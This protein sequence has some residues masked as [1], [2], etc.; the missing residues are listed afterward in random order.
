MIRLLLI[1]CFLLGQLL[2]FSRDYDAE[3]LSQKTNITV[4]NGKLIKTEY[5]EIKINNRAGDQYTKVTIPYSKLGKITK[6]HAYI[7]NS[8]GKVIRHI[9]K[10]EITDRSSISDF[11]FYEDDYVKEFTLKHNTYP[12]TI[13]FSY[14]THQDEFLY[15]DSWTPVI[16]NE[17][18]THEATLNL[19]IQK[20]YPVSFSEQLIDSTVI[21]TS[22]S[23][24]KYTWYASYVDIVK[25]ELFSPPLSDFLPSVE[26]VPHFFEFNLKGSFKTWADYGNWQ[27][28]LLS[29]TDEFPAGEKHK[30]TTMVNDI[31]D[32]KEK[33]K[34]LYHYLQDNTRYINI[35]IETGGLKPYPAIYV[36]KNKYGDCKALTNY[37]KTVL[38]IAGIRSYYTKI[39][40]G[41]PIKKIN[42]EFPSQQ[43]NH[44]ILF[45]PLKNDTIWLDCT[46]DGP[47]GYLG[48]FTQNRDAFV[49]E[50]NNSHFIH[51]P[52]L[53]SSEIIESRAIRIIYRQN[54]NSKVIF[55]NRYRGIMFEKLLELERTYSESDKS[56]IIRNYFMEKGFELAK[57][58][59][60]SSHRDSLQILLF[61]ET[62]APHMYKKY[63]D[64]ILVSNIPFSI[65][66]FEEP[67]KRKLPVQI[68]YPVFK[69]DTLVY[70]ITPGY[71]LSENINNQS[72]HNRFGH[73][74]MEFLQVDEGI[75]VIK[76]L[77]IKSGSYTTDEYRDFYNFIAQIDELEN[78]IHIT[79]VK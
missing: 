16:D 33:I 34:I 18:P 49:I 32:D 38:D 66:H 4:S 68:D 8:Y 22:E 42:N 54:E 5:F 74:K 78:K 43:F 29:N 59:I 67:E 60:T 6:I 55:K 12:Y 20:N 73:Y 25:S 44:V 69:M 14:E 9:K 52:S 70:D 51:T 65:P 45:I 46:S 71:N 2:S 50:K 53:D 76:N 7:K 75:R 41:N 15:L 35:T 61:Q 11:S 62:S 30:I 21:D 79:L 13:V 63:G 72:I 40:A 3:L 37:F 47:F 28:E 56:M 57:H 48:T 31:Q 24:I 23:H 64:E 1:S 77:F 19:F 17:I 27:N 39:H 10:S 26:I 36:A 58:R